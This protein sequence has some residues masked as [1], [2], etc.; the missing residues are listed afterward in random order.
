MP[1]DGHERIVGLADAAFLATGLAEI[2]V[3]VDDDAQGQGLGKLLSEAVA[4]VALQRGANRLKAEMLD[5]N[6]PMLRLLERL[7]RTVRTVEDGRSVAYTRLQQ[8]RRRR[9]LSQ[10]ARAPRVGAGARGSS[11]PARVSRAMTRRSPPILCRRPPEQVVHVLAAAPR[12]DDRRARPIRSTSTRAEHDQRH[13]GGVTEARVAER[14]RASSRT[15]STTGASRIASEPA[16]P[17]L[18]PGA[19]Q[20]DQQPPAS[21]AT[22]ATVVPAVR[23][24]PRSTRAAAAARSRT[25]AAA[26]RPRRPRSRPACER[27]YVDALRAQRRGPERRLR[28]ARARHAG[29][30]ASSRCSTPR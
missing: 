16:P 21:T 23:G 13:V 3:V 25:C 27:A 17:A 22:T 4:S 1:I 15:A 20:P 14:D 11:V 18:R 28:S 9:P 2:G 7:G 19:G 24:P 10:G 5:G 8:R 29:R 26:A 12:D 30:S 6:E